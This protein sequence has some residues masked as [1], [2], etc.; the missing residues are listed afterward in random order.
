MKFI[1]PIK[2]KMPT[3]IGI[4]TFISMINT[5]SESLKARTVFIFQHFNFYEQLKYHAQFSVKK[6][7]NL[8]ACLL[9]KD[10]YKP[11]C[12]SIFKILSAANDRLC[13]KN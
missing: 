10:A 6:F 13:F 4:L 2:V 1:M 11:G 12:V 8:R 9:I 5:S 7:Y 3:I